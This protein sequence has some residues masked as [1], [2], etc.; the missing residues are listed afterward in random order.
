MKSTNLNKVFSEIFEEINENISQFINLGSNWSFNKVMYLDINV[1]QHDPLKG[2]SY[3]P[4]PI[5]LRLKNAI[6]NVKNND[7]ECFKWAITSAV[8]FQI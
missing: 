3:L 1:N 7:N 8:F 6:I 2:N 4:L 5:F